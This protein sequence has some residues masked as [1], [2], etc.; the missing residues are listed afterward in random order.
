V[1]PANRPSPDTARN[2]TKALSHNPDLVIINLPSNDAKNNYTVAEQQANYEMAMA[3]LAERNIPVWVT[4]TQPR[5][6]LTPQQ[7]AAQFTMRDWTL[8]RFGEKAIDF[9][10]GV[11]NAD[12][13]INPVYN[14]DGIHVN[15]EAHHIFYSR[16]IAKH[17]LDTLCLRKNIPPVAN[18]GGNL[19]VS[20]PLDFVTLNATASMDP[21]GSIVR[22]AWRQIA[23]PGLSLLLD[24]QAAIAKALQLLPG[25]YT[26]ELT[27]TDNEGASAKDT[28]RVSVLIQTGNSKKIQVNIYGGSF[29]AGNG[30]NNWNVQ[31]SLTTTDLLYADGMASTVSAS[32]SMSNAIADNGLLYPVAM[33][34]AEVGRT[35]SY[36]TMP[37]WI[38]LNGL[39]NTKQYDIELYASR[40]ATGN[41]TKFIIGGVSLSV[42]T[43][44]NFNDKALFTGVIP[45]AGQVRISIERLNTYNYINGF[46]VTEAGSL[47]ARSQTQAASAQRPMMIDGTADTLVTMALTGYPNPFTSVIQFRLNDKSRGT[48]MIRLTDQYGN[49]V[50]YLTIVKPADSI[51]GTIHTAE[52]PAGTYYLKTSGAMKSVVTKVIKR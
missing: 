20:L 36:S 16:V 50:K 48:V 14:V 51:S 45:V 27:V 44:R 15:T 23:G 18:A 26:Y 4:T 46:T 7:M 31:S 43:D 21:D 33:C 10:T 34:P 3:M 42:L 19:A 24:Q 12:G 30:W 6:A 9:W 22:Y 40:N 11:A 13:T 52:L 1:P 29:P 47:P 35:T 2:I 49:M 17:L 41:S 5:N 25:V 32:M 39:D 8:Q 38:T 37:R 28:L